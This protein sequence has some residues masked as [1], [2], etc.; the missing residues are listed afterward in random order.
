MTVGETRS[1]TAL[2]ISLAVV[3]IFGMTGARSVAIHS[4]SEIFSGTCLH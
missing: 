1:M 2:N 3:L 4:L